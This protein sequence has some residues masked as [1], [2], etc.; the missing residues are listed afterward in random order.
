MTIP[1]KA[2]MVDNLTIRLD[3]TSKTPLIMVKNSIAAILQRLISSN[4]NT[5]SLSLAPVNSIIVLAKW[6]RIVRTLARHKMLILVSRN[7]MV[8]VVPTLAIQNSRTMSIK[9]KIMDLQILGRAAMASLVINIT[10]VHLQHQDGE[11]SGS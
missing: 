1:R 7:S 5:V 11:R 6:I 3:S 4:L 9:V 8:M 10:M 2:L